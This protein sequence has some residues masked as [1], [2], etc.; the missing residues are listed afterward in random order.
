MS[1]L[2]DMKRTILLLSFLALFT[3]Y[4]M[5]AQIL[6]EKAQFS[7]KARGT[8]IFELNSGEHIYTYEPEDGWYKARKKKGFEL[9]F[10]GVAQG[11]TIEQQLHLSNFFRLQK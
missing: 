4:S 10:R 8:A 3:G 6:E 9:R 11:I 2:I 7:E 5:D 1:E